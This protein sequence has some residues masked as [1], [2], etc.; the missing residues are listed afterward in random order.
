MTTAI[1]F[2]FKPIKYNG[3]YYVDGGLT[4]GYPVEF[5]VD[6]YLGIWIRGSDWDIKNEIKDIFEFIT[7][8]NCIKPYNVDHLDKK[9]TI[10][11][12]SNI[13]FSEFSIDKKLKQDMIKDGYNITKRHFEEYNL[14]NDI[15]A[16]DLATDQHPVY[17]DPTLEDSS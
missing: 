8:L 15:F 11:Y 7:K 5:T 17:T 16:T 4:G 3:S 13:H 9:R 12:V 14:T 6:N 2:M 10:I 1:P